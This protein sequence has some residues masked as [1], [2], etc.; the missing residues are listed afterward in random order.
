VP[1]EAIFCPLPL[2]GL[3]QNS[4][5]PFFLNLPLQ[6]TLS[7]TLSGLISIGKMFAHEKLHVYGK[8]LDF[9]HYHPA[10]DEN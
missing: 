7:H 5:F 6:N 10:E 8:A 9:S 4:N 3:Q 2:R 1:N